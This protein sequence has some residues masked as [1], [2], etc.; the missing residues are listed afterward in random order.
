LG[1]AGFELIRDLAPDQVAYG[2]NSYEFVLN[3]PTIHYD[4]WGL[5]YNNDLIKCYARCDKFC[6]SAGNPQDC[7]RNCYANCEDNPNKP[8]SPIPP[9]PKTPIV[10]PEKPLWPII[11]ECA[12]LAWD[13][14]KHKKSDPDAKK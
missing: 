6:A 3:S 9:L 14:F 4:A 1:E 10:N 11:K 12:K 2:V 13:W 8:P 7:A 5:D